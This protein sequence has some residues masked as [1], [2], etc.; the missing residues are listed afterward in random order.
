MNQAS[1]ARLQSDASISAAQGPSLTRPTRQ[2]LPALQTNVPSP[3]LRFSKW[4]SAYNSATSKN[5][6]R[7]SNNL[8]P[9]EKRKSRQQEIET[10]HLMT[11][12]SSAAATKANLPRRG[13]EQQEGEPVVMS[14]TSFPG[15]EW[16]PGGFNHYED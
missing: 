11:A 4:G 7:G 10:E 15:Q 6:S 8:T 5:S 2:S 16:M 9:E 14:A 1:T 13:Q 3:N 12:E